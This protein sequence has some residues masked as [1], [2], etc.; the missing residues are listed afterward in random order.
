MPRSNNYTCCVSHPLVCFFY[1][2]TVSLFKPCFI[3]SM[4]WLSITDC[5]N[6]NTGLFQLQI[7]DYSSIHLV[8]SQGNALFPCC[9]SFRVFVLGCCNVL[10]WRGWNS[11][12]V[13]EAQ[14]FGSQ[15]YARMQQGEE[16]QV[17]RKNI[18]WGGALLFLNSRS[19]AHVTDGCHQKWVLGK[20]H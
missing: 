14:R 3:F 18:V 16:W 7:L 10:L 9:Y 11:S 13:L 2:G 8:R 5:K 20:E 4:L 12:L 6:T 15:S 19:T 17:E 1:L